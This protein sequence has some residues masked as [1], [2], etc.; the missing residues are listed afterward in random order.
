MVGNLTSWWDVTLC[1][2]VSRYIVSGGMCN[3]VV[4]SADYVVSGG[5]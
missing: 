5:M 1:V 4:M 2:Y 3:R